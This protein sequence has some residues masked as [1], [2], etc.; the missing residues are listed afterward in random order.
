[1]SLLLEAAQLVEPIGEAIEGGMPVFGTCAGLILLATE[2]EDGRPDQY[3]FGRLDIGVRRNAY[4]RQLESFETELD[5]AGFDE[6]VPG[7]FIRAPQI[8]RVGEGVEV[9][10]RDDGGMPVLVRHGNALGA[11]FHPELSGDTRIHRLFV[12]AARD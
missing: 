12:N 7:V 5:V 4:G 10:A 6:P 9:L 11:V 8:V 2:V 1:M 3:S